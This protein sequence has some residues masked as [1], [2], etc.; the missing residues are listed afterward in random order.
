MPLEINHKVTARTKRAQLT[1]PPPQSILNLRHLTKIAA[2]CD[3]PKY[4]F[5]IK[6]VCAIFDTMMKTLRGRD[7]IYSDNLIQVGTGEAMQVPNHCR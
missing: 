4:L 2:C 3:L 6:G 5:D 7:C 1:H